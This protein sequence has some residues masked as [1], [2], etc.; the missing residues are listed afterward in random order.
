MICIDVRTLGDPILTDYKQKIGA[1]SGVDIPIRAS[2]HG[3]SRRVRAYHIC[4]ITP[5]V[6]HI[7]LVAVGAVRQNL[8]NQRRPGGSPLRPIWGTAS[9][10]GVVIPGHLSSRY[11]IGARQ[12]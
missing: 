3:G 12:P 11:V 9:V 5:L 2:E 10:A 8:D 7:L 6:N 4:S 1:V